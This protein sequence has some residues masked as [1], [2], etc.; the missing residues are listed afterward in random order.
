MVVVAIVKVLASKRLKG[1][2]Y[3]IELCIGKKAIGKK[4]F[5]NC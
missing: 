3:N 2:L 4:I 1:T 5:G